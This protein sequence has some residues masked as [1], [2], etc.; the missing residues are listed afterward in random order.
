M[1]FI[2]LNYRHPFFSIAVFFVLILTVILSNKIFEKIKASKQNRKIANFIK[3]FELSKKTA[4]YKEFLLNKEQKTS[5][6]ALLA[7]LKSRQ[8]E[9]EEAIRIYLDLL[10]VLIDKQSKVEIMIMLGQTYFKA[11]FMQRSKY[12]LLEALKLST[13]N[14]QALHLLLV[15]YENLKDYVKAADVV[16]V[17]E[18]NGENVEKQRAATKIL[19]VINNPQLTN[20]KKTAQIIAHLKQDAS[21]SRIAY[22]YLS[23][24]SPADFWQNLK[25]EQVLELIDILWGFEKE[26]VDF[27]IVEKFPALKEIYAAKGYLESPVRSRVFALDMLMD[28]S[29]RQ[30]ADLKFEYFCKDCGNTFPLSFYR[31]PMCH[32]LF[33]MGINTDLAP[34]GQARASDSSAGFY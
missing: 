7:S 28:P 31:C 34:R 22:E 17:L 10:E 5:S 3:S 33:S 15:I 8:G 26:S 12:I 25:E 16:D 18:E 24:F 14:T 9:Y 20:D 1:E 13:R 32:S 30:K 19:A 23:S 11:G 6:L 29:A 4:D 2:I 21:I 27:G